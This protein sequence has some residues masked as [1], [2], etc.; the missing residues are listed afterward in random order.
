M[1]AANLPGAKLTFKADEVRALVGLTK[2]GPGDEV[3][4]GDEPQRAAPGS[5]V[6]YA[7]DSPH[8]PRGG[9]DLKG[10]HFPGGQF[11]PHDRGT[12]VPVA[13]RD[14]NPYAPG[15]LKKTTRSDNSTSKNWSKRSHF[16]PRNAGAS[17]SA[18]P[19]GKRY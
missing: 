13:D 10:K 7:Q 6:G 1:K 5:P 15:G 17:R 14:D 19:A 9:I 3:V 11:I 4:G 2:P 12:T 8:A 16:G 18:L